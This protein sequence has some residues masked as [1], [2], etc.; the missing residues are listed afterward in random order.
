MRGTAYYRR[1][2]AVHRVLVRRDESFSGGILRLVVSGVDRISLEIHAFH[3]VSM[4]CASHED[5]RKEA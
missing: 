4:L 1:H 5:E 2:D 3:G